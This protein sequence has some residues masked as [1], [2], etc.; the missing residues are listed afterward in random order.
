MDRFEALLGE[1][2]APDGDGLR[3]TGTAVPYGVVGYP[4]I[5]GKGVAVRIQPGAFTGRMEGAELRVMHQR[6]ELPIA[7]YPAGGLTL[8]DGADALALAA[9]LADTAAARD[10]VALARSGV[11]LGLS[12]EADVLQATNAGDVRDVTAARLTAIAVVS[13]PAWRDAT[14]RAERDR[15]V[16]GD[17]LR[18]LADVL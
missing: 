16:A 6:S 15:R 13:R 17:A 4:T 8:T 18:E 10:V 12:V 1:V 2:A 9:E 14:L 3:L 7:A 5:A 11:P